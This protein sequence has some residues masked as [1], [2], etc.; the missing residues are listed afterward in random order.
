MPRSR[1]SLRAIARMRRENRELRER[2]SVAKRVEQT[3]SLTSW[4]GVSKI[5]AEVKTATRL[6]FV[7]EVSAS[8][9]DGITTTAVRRVHA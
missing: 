5:H 3:T 6:G 4:T 9:D 8:G 7:V 2:L 1:M